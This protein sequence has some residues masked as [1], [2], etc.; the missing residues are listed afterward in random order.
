MCKLFESVSE[1]LQIEQGKVTKKNLWK[2]LLVDIQSRGG[3]KLNV[4][5]VKKLESKFFHTL[6]LEKAKRLEGKVRFNYLYSIIVGLPK[7]GS[8]IASVFM[9]NTVREFSVFPELEEHLFLPIDVHI[10]NILTNKLQVFSQ[11]ELSKENPLKS[12]K[13]ML[14]Q[15]Q[16]TKIHSPR[17]E[18]DALWFIGHIFCNKK[19][20]FVC[21]KLCW[22]RKYCRQNFTA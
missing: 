13:S 19:S 6:D 16:L 21:K 20:G 12:K 3:P 2:I 5:N 10:K 22:I 7:I 11:N 18:L 14:F 9:K 4:A 8:K 1:P 15:E 17:V